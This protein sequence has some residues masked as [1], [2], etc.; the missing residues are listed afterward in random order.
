MVFWGMK[1]VVWKGI[2]LGI[3]IQ[4]GRVERQV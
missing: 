4:S 1:V 3:D 2:D